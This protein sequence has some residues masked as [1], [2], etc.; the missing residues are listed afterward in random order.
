M[1]PRDKKINI[2]HKN[3]SNRNFIALAYPRLIQN[4]FWWQKVRLGNSWQTLH[5]QVSHAFEYDM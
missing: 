1:A 5:G 3:T 2:G 4:Q